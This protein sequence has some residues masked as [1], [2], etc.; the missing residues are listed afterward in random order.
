MVGAAG[1]VSA[2]FLSGCGVGI[3][4]TASAGQSKYQQTW[5]KSYAA[6]TCSDFRTS[7]TEHERWA[8]GADML[9]NARAKGDGPRGMPSDQLVT[10]FR[11]GVETGCVID[12]M[13]VA[14]TGAMLHLAEKARFGGS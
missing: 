5:S 2:L 3:S 8:A 13:S 10:T 12:T 4:K 1:M 11:L 9:A 6:T 7:M 14:E